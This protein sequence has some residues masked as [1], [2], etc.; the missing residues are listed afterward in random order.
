MRRSTRANLSDATAKARA[1]GVGIFVCDLKFPEVGLD[2]HVA[3]AQPLGFDEPVDEV[4][5]FGDRRLETRLVF[6][7][8][9]FVVGVVFAA[10]YFGFCVDAGIEGVLG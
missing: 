4:T 9:R 2:G 8:E 7:C 6:G 5:L 3:A 1:E 10:D